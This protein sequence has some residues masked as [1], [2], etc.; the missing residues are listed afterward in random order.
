MSRSGLMLLAAVLLAGPGCATVAGGLP[1]VHRGDAPEY[2]PVLARYTRNV[3]VYDGV[4][5]ILIATGVVETNEFLKARFLEDARIHDRKPEEAPPLES[6]YRETHDGTT[7]VL[8]F[9][10]TL[11]DW[12]DLDK[13]DTIWRVTLEVGGHVL[14]PVAVKALEEE[15]VTLRHLFPFTNPWGTLYLLTF[16][17]SRD[18]LHGDVQL[19]IAGVPARVSLDY[20]L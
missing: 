14:E 1:Q 17:V 18:E 12:E 19:R 15:D 2:D 6:I 20:E 8:F 7:V 4:E 11:P 16:P 10:A 13:P 3:R 5:R 9:D